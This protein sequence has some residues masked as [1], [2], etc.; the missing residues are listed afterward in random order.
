MS[1][2]DASQ[3]QPD[4]LA[5]KTVPPG[6]GRPGQPPT[7]PS[8]VSWTNT[9]GGA[10]STATNWST[11]AVPTSS[12]SVTVAVAGVYT[13][14]ITAAAAANSL[15][16]TDASATIDDTAAL[17]VGSIFALT[18]GTFALGSGG[19]VVGGT[20][21]VGAGGGFQGSGGTLSGVK[22][23]GTL[24]LSEF[25]ST[26]TV[27]GSNS[28][29]GASGAGA[30]TINL[31]A[32]VSSWNYLN[33]AGSSMLSNVT[34]DIGNSWNNSDFN[35]PYSVIE[36]DDITGKGSVLML[37]S[38]VSIIQT[39]YEAALISTGDNRDG[40]VNDGTITAAFSGGFFE[41]DATNFTNN[42]SI[43]VGNDDTL[44]L[45]G[46]ITSALVDSIETASGGIIWIDGAVSG[47]TITAGANNIG[48]Y[49]GTLSGVTYQGALD[50]AGCGN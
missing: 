10:W 46:T 17:S 35:G 12:S 38:S 6:G 1:I 19:E 3:G 33:V 42:G 5:V 30:A 9:A 23:E 47:G 31:S 40:I 39:G 49:D 37:A 11:G 8:S 7:S 28:F 45:T 20:I 48:G 32:N 36:N 44:Y 41:I 15:T 21:T 25:N 50:L 16:V 34:V 14:D 2:A 43:S 26:L 29:A 13:I 22:Y 18:A 27:A 4:N 24:D